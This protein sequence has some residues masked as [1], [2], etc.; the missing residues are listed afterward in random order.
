MLLHTDSYNAN[1]Y[2]V[3]DFLQFDRSKLPIKSNLS[4]LGVIFRCQRFHVHQIEMDWTTISINGTQLK[5]FMRMSRH[6]N[7]LMCYLHQIRTV[8]SAKVWNAG[9]FLMVQTISEVKLLLWLINRKTQTRQRC[10]WLW[11]RF[12][13]DKN[14]AIRGNYAWNYVQFDFFVEFSNADGFKRASDRRRRR[15]RLSHARWFLLE[16]RIKCHPIPTE[17]PTIKI[18]TS[19]GVSGI[20]TLFLQKII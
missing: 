17:S 12:L 6:L 1:C 5:A 15:R 9:P 20:I 14:N 16:W 4:L 19:D 8:R 13:V 11:T 7:H 10:N 2:Q 3:S 18:N